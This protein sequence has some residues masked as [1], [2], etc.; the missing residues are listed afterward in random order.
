MRLPLA[1]SKSSPNFIGSWLIQD[2]SICDE[3]INYFEREKTKHKQG[4]LSMGKDLEAKN[5]IDLGIL[6]QQ[7]ALPENKFLQTYF[8]YLSEF[9]SD[10]LEQWPFLK[11][12]AKEVEIG[13][14]NI[15][16]YEKGQHF[17]RIHTERCSI[18]TL[19]RLFAW[20]T[21]LNDVSPEDGG[22]TIFTHYG[23][24]LQPRKGQTLIWPA[25][26]THAHKGSILKG[27]SKYIITG[28]M[29]FQPKHGC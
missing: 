1:D 14:F 10:Y 26:W 15:Q 9:Y 17:Q 7:I 18:A 3:L 2:P 21:Y 4:E 23:L 20:M 5:S 19:H 27:N 13:K 22:S 28:W 6:P 11:N 24:K 25:E 16:R 8:K 12:L 29:H